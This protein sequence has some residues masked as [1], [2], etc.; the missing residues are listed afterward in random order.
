MGDPAQLH[1]KESA[2]HSLAFTLTL[3]SQMNYSQLNNI[4]VLLNVHKDAYTL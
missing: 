2:L 4:L 1:T 3:V